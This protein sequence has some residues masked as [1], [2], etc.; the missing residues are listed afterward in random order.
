MRV[1]RRSTALVLACASVFAAIGAWIGGRAG[2]DARWP[3]RRAEAPHTA[4]TPIHAPDPVEAEAV[5]ESRAADAPLG[6]TVHVIDAQTKEAIA[7]ASVS[8]A[9]DRRALIEEGMAP[10]LVAVTNATGSFVIASPK[11]AQVEACW[12]LVENAAYS[13]AVHRV[14]HGNRSTDAVTIVLGRSRP[15]EFLIRYPDGSPVTGATVRLASVL[16]DEIASRAAPRSR[17]IA[18]A[19][20]PSAVSGADGS[21]TVVIDPLRRYWVRVTAS[22]CAPLVLDELAE[23]DRKLGR[24]D[25][26]V[27]PI[28]V[29]GIVVLDP[30][31]G[32]PSGRSRGSLCGAVDWGPRFIPDVHNGVNAEFAQQIN[33]LVRRLALDNV[34]LML[35]REHPRSRSGPEPAFRGAVDVSSPPEIIPLRWRRIDEFLRSDVTEVFARIS[36]DD[37]ASLR[38]RFIDDSGIV[39]APSTPWGVAR[40][41]AGLGFQPVEVDGWSTFVIPPGTYFIKNDDSVLF[42][43]S[44]TDI[45]V[46]LGTGEEAERLVHLEPKTAR[47][48]AIAHDE[49]GMP[50]MNWRMIALP[51]D[52]GAIVDHSPDRLDG[53]RRFE[54]LPAGRLSVI[55]KAFGFED[56]VIEIELTP[57]EVRMLSFTL[58]RNSEEPK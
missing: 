17:V 34:Q 12:I 9:I 4:E 42:G 10:D 36:D 58:R 43:T 33:E 35:A 3:V 20:A 11:L 23:A 22:G 30:A 31:T 18:D 26:I 49:F 21:A 15:H 8:V 40:S 44:F 7:G 29:A 48:E 57:G 32:K 27:C 2:V 5:R 16:G 50:L 56:S 52:N 38:V 19:S 28:V 55:S 6:L 25:V 37:L 51:G 41:K 45:E 13:A 1:T 24:T 39:A 53:V 54:G 14:V 46:E 47:V